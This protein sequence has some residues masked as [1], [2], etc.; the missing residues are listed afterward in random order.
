VLVGRKAWLWGCVAT[1]LASGCAAGDDASAVGGIGATASDT[2]G[3]NMSSATSPSS[4]GSASGSTG[5]EPP[6]EDEEE[7]EFQVPEASGRFVYSTASTL[8]IVAVIDS[9]NLAI[10]VIE[11]GQEPTVV[12]ALGEPS[13]DEGAVAVLNRASQEVSLLRTSLS[14][15]EP[16]DQRVVTPGANNL[17][18]SPDGAYVIAYHDIDGP[19]VAGPG[20]DQEI[21][22]LDAS[23]GGASW[24]MTVG[25]HP[26]DV[27]FSPNGARAFIVTA[28][29][30]N[31][32][33]LAQLG[34]I[35]K[36][37][38]IPVIDDPGTDPD[39]VEVVVA[40]RHGIAL[41]RVE[42][43]PVLVATDL[44]SGEQ[45]T[46]ELEA[47]PT[48]L[49]IA[50]DDSFALATVRVLGGSS[51][52]ELALPAGPGATLDSFTVGTEFVGVAEL[53]ADGQTAIL[54]TTVEAGDD[55]G[56]GS[57]SG[58]S[59]SGSSTDTDTDTDGT[60]GPST[61]S[62]S[63]T[64]GGPEIPGGD[65]RQRVTILRRDGNVWAEP[66][67]LFNDV[68][69]ESVGIAPDSA[70][71]ILV[72]VE[73]TSEE[74]QGA[75]WSYTLVDLDKDFPVK[76]RQTVEAPTGAVLF[77]PEGERA[78][79]LVRW[80]DQDVR[81]VDRVDLRTFVVESLGLGSPPEG[82]GF[83]PTT[84]KIFVSQEH[85]SGRITFIAENGLVET[86]TGYV[87]N[88]AVKD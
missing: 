52:V 35:G 85:P 63:E 73:D 6:P 43:E 28:D 88:D 16:V 54:Y 19:Q 59:T 47:A 11:V 71:A 30:V 15:T 75:P 40:A 83:V 66:I 45:W 22:V 60:A 77:T 23:P 68:A 26:R 70:S 31:V 3:G 51:V 38:V 72:H 84:E 20:S 27:L 42:G 80:D 46:Y 44:D 82:A 81:R 74:G 49:D 2:E 69:I 56:G 10:E 33:P 1:L 7:G 5:G 78:V 13:G 67:T 64:S 76:K 37:D 86:L 8:N 39:R 4:S 29:G 58:G 25:A 62:S 79:V 18:V 36:P 53:A 12:A 48:D 41:A 50:T 55:P 9:A 24:E 65:T 14:G 34:M 57:T 61:T 21:T 87:L 17:A 32:L